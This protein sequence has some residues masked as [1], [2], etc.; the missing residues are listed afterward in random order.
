MKTNST[1][2]IKCDKNNNRFYTISI[3]KLRVQN[4][5]RK[6]RIPVIYCCRRQGITRQQTSTIAS[7]TTAALQQEMERVKAAAVAAGTAGDFER[8]RELWAEF[9]VVVQAKIAGLL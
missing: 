8:A 2:K 1:Q 9:Q 6:K 4:A 3:E 5:P 7:M